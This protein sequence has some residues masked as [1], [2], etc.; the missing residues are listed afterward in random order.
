MPQS[1]LPEAS[2]SNRRGR[3]PVFSDDALRTATRYSYARHVRSRRGSQ[4][5]VYRHFAIAAIGLYR[6]SFPEEGAVL[7]WLLEPRPRH[8]LLTELGR[9]AKPRSGS[10]ESL[11]WDAHDVSRL[12]EAAFLVAERKPLT[13]DGVAI[14]RELRRAA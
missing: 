8:S 9:V 5:L 1:V 12:I 2:S 10:G 6:E 13:K 7:G 3:R 14:I 11:Q 4:D